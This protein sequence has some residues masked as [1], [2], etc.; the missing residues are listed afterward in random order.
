MTKLLIDTNIVLDL[1]AN[2]EPF[3]DGAAQIFSLADKHKVILSVSSLSF[4]TVYYILSKSY[5]PPEVLA[6]LRKLKILVNVLA[7][8]EKIIE[9][10]LNNDKFDDFED[11]LQYHTAV[12][13]GQDI[14]LTRNQKDFKKS[15]IPVMNAE[16]YLVS[17]A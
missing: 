10:A 8:N 1:L 9:L 11:D 14:I 12:E 13:N 2:R 4:V 16:E 7:L 15:V 6:V 5:Q 17:I 3:Y